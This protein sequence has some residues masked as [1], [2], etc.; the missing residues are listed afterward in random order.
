MDKLDKQYGGNSAMALNKRLNNLSGVAS[1]TSPR[2]EG[3][4]KLMLNQMSEIQS[5]SK[6]AAQQPLNLPNKVAHHGGASFYSFAKLNPNESQQNISQLETSAMKGGFTPTNH[7]DSNVLNF[8]KMKGELQR[9]FDMDQNS[10]LN[11]TENGINELQS[12]VN[13][14]KNSRLNNNEEQYMRNV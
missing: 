13:L 2:N 12:P 6:I 14:L 3:F 5:L 1:D 8:N 11:I 9:L 7:D 10:H 4:S